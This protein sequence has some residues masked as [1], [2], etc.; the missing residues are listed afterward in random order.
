MLTKRLVTFPLA[1]RFPIQTTRVA[2]LGAGFFHKQRSLP[3]PEKGP[4]LI[5]ASSVLILPENQ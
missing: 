3:Q 1:N 2:L 4:A 5:Y